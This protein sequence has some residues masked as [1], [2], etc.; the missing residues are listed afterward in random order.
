[1]KKIHLLSVLIVMLL[2]SLVLI[3]VGAGSW[4]DKI[5]GGGQ[6]TTYGGILFN[7]SVSAWDD[8]AGVYGGQMQYSRYDG[9]L[10]MHATVDCVHVNSDGLIAVAAGP[11]KAQY[12]PNNYVGTTGGWMVVMLKEGGVGYG[13]EVRVLGR[14]EAD[15]RA[16]CAADYLGPFFGYVFDG[17]FNIRSK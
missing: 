7:L 9:T 14:T 17:N 8:G 16:F 13:D 2:A 6:V 10:D 15:A 5:T 3:P 4:D 1:M 12:D 11:A